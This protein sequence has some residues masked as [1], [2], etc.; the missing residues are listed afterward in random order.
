MSGN[1]NTRYRGIRMRRWGK[2]VSEI[3]EPQRSGSRTNRIW[4]GS[5]RS[6]E[7]A[8]LH[9]PSKFKNGSSLTAGMIYSVN[10]A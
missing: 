8:V 4:L 9:Y 10:S 7:E 5:F 2:W 6:A 3:R 1:S